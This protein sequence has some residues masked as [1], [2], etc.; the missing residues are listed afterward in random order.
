MNRKNK[1]ISPVVATVII[2]A[3]AIALAIA[4][5]LWASGLVGIFTRFEEVKVIS[6]YA[7]VGTGSLAG[8]FNV[9]LTLKNTGSADA[10]IDNVII[11]GKPFSSWTGGITVKIGG[12][13]LDPNVGYALKA[14]DQKDMSIE[15]PQAVG[16]KSG[17]TLDIKIHTA[18][19][20]DYAKAVVLP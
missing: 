1:G 19:G 4:V 17:Q 8:G 7:E 11:N 20:H 10:T 9:T 18:A 13:N 16:F 12:Q 5:A 2:V 3:I 6:A 15:I 14:G